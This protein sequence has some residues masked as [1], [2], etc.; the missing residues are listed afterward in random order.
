[1]QSF[2]LV[3][4]RLETLGKRLIRNPVFDPQPLSNF[5]Q[6]AAVHALTNAS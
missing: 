4:K 1:V 3:D 5:N 2:E 6:Q